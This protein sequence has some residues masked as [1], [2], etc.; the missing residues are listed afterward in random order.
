MSAW[1]CTAE[2]SAALI[3]HLRTD[4]NAKGYVP[5]ILDGRLTP[6]LETVDRRDAL[7]ALSTLFENLGAQYAA[8]LHGRPRFLVREAREVWR[9]AKGDEAKFALLEQYLEDERAGRLA[10]RTITAVD[11]GAELIIVDGNKRAIAIYEAADPDGEE[12]E[13]PVFV[14]RPS[15]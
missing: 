4:D 13:L 2:E 10:N 9:Q 8:K 11:T 6:W 1:R 5:M 15:R 3:A 12:L 7:G 14:L